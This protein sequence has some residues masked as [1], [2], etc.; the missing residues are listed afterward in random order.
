MAEYQ[1]K[2]QA[3]GSLKLEKSYVKL[4]EENAELA[5]KLDYITKQEIIDAIKKIADA[6]GVEVNF[7]YENLKNEILD[8]KGKCH[9]LT[10][11]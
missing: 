3:D 9:F 4:S 8:K 7:T 10:N 6:T 5:Q 11:Y 2:K 1:V